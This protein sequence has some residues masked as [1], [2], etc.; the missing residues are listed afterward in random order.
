M[1]R[2]LNYPECCI[3]YYI[4]ADWS[5]E[6]KYEFYTSKGCG[7]RTCKIHNDFT[8]D[9]LFNLIGRRPPDQHICNWRQIHNQFNRTEDWENI[10]LKIKFE[11]VETQERYYYK[12]TSLANCATYK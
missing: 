8:P 12:T 3:Q 11:D 6:P 1:G 4:N 10:K 5:K 2:L 9:E 7:F